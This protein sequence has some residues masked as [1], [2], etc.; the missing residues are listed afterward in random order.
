MLCIV[1]MNQSGGMEWINSRPANM[2]HLVVIQTLDEG[3]II[4]QGNQYGDE[5]NL[6][7]IDGQGNLEYNK[8]IIVEITKEGEHPIQSFS[9]SK[10]LKTSTNEYLFF[11]AITIIIGAGNVT[12]MLR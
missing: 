6:W 1:K 12:M 3:F 4:S 10:I 11:I 7:K 5:L 2:G 8:T 9:I